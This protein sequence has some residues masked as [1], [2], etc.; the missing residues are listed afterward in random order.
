[1]SCPI[2]GNATTPEM[3]PFC[4]KRCADRDLARWFNGSYAVPS[5]D[6]EDIEELDEALEE[7]ARD[8]RGPEKPH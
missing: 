3:R 6:P 8:Q 4:S 7:A 2:C 5:T 1:M